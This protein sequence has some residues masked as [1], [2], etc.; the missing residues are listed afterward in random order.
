M[1]EYRTAIRTCH[2]P[3][4]F[5]FNVTLH[6]DVELLNRKI[7]TVLTAVHRLEE[8]MAL[9]F[10]KLE[11]QVTAIND[12]ADAAEAMLAGISQELRD[13]RQTVGDLPTMQ[14][15]LDDLATKLETEAGELGAAVAANT[16]AAPTP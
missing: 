8:K 2:D 9:D 12:A 6:A 11:A 3:C 4:V 10:T 15:R 13:L 7:D 5:V 14:S 1:P 16:P